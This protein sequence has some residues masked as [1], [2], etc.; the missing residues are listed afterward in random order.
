MSTISSAMGRKSP[1]PVKIQFLLTTFVANP[2]ILV[3]FQRVGLC[4]RQILTGK[5]T[6]KLLNNNYWYNGIERRLYRLYM[7][8]RDILDS[9]NELEN[10]VWNEK[11]L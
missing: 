5:K 3:S 6:D 7:Q 8:H 2:G 4:I 9:C 10:S 11:N 1:K